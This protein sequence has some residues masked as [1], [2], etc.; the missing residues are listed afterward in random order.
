M[1]DAKRPGYK[2]S[3]FYL[4][5]LAQ[6]LGLLWASGLV[7]EGTIADKIIGFAA[8]VLAQLGYTVS[9]GLAKGK[10]SLDAGGN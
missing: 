5:L 8:M 7:S 10:P 6:V 4:T 3:E 9:R 1:S 2:T